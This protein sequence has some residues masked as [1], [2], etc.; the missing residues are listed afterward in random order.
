VFGLTTPWWEII[1]RT[2]VVYIVV[3]VLLRSP[4]S[5]SWGR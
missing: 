1:L 4:E 3:L 2:A 5:V